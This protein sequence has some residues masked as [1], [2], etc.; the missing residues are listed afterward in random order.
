M[1]GSNFYKIPRHVMK[2]PD[3]I[4]VIRKIGVI[5]FWLYIFLL[6]LAEISRK[7]GEKWTDEDGRIFVFAQQEKIAEE[8]GVDL[9]AI[10]RAFRKMKESGLVDIRKMG[11]GHPARVYV[12][13]FPKKEDD[14][15]K[16]GGK[17]RYDEKQGKYQGAYRRNEEKR[18]GYTKN[19]EWENIKSL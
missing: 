12:N 4:S 9:S 13:Q 14:I 16:N 3:F 18:G 11:R 19:I 1:S 8:I 17:G 6:N 5:G 10:T 15:S 2:D 7:N